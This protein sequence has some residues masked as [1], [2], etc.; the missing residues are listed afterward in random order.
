MK[1]ILEPLS[2]MGA[3]ISSQNGRAPLT[4][5]GTRLNAINCELSTV[6]SQVKSAIMFASLFV[7]EPTQ[8]TEKIKTHNHT[9]VLMG[10]LMADIKTGFNTVTVKGGSPLV[11]LPIG[12]SGDMSAAAYIIAEAV[13]LKKSSVIITHVCVNVM[14]MGI[15]NVLR[16]MGAYV[17][18]VNR[19]KMA[20]E[21]VMDIIAS[22]SDLT[23]VT[24]S[25]RT[26]PMLID[27]LPLIAVIACFAKGKTV[28][29]DA[30]E[31]KL[32]ESNRI[33]A[34]V[35]G[36]KKMG[37]SIEA[38]DDGM[39]IEGGAELTGTQ[40]DSFGDHRIAMSLA[41]A[42]LLAQGETDI[43]GGECVSASFPDFYENI[44]RK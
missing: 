44:L 23:G 1:N 8:I 28:I 10:F 36:L 17:E 38:T 40:V 14:R 30:A 22:S 18:V 26:I 7:P 12:I 19:R 3:K 35:D 41:I 31:L 27:E 43:I 20:G 24:I 16:E 13:L 39:I 32:K 6:S 9:E 29:K 21:S 34:I 15:I 4:I 42:G 37:A 5:E 33:D 11:A 25:G 2:L